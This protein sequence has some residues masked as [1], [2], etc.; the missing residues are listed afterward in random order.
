VL[1]AWAL[2]ATLLPGA[3][4]PGD[5]PAELVWSFRLSSLGTQAVLWAGI[6]CVFGVLGERAE[7]R[8]GRGVSNLAAEGGVR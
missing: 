1:V 5:A 3:D 2:L 6:G 4:T 8:E 7:A